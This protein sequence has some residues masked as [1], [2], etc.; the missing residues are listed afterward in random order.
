MALFSKLTFSNIY[1]RNTIKVSNGLESDQDWHSVFKLFEKV[2]SSK[3][4]LP[5][6][7]KELISPFLWRPDPEVI[8]P[9]S[10]S[11][12]VSTKFILLIKVKMSTIVG[13]LTF[14]SM[15]NTTSERLKA[16]NFLIC[17]Y[18]SF[19]EQLKFHAQL[20]LAWK[21]FITSGPCIIRAFSDN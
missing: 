1:F 5:P 21:S 8:K 6:A 18:F 20:S 19:Y 2:I 15:I 17:V 7:G 3:Q 4:R 10:Y 11:T 12:Q 9:F 16:R 14:I 13:I